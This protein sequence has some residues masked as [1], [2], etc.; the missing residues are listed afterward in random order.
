MAGI[1]YRSGTN[2]DLV[3][4]A[5]QLL[6]SQVIEQRN[7]RWLCH[8]TP[9]ANLE[10]IKQNGLKTRDLLFDWETTVTDPTRF[11]RFQNAICLSISKPNSWMFN[12]KQEQGLDLC[13]LLISPEVL[14]KKN[15]LFYPHNAATAS[16]RNINIEILK[17]EKG[18]E[19]MFSNPISYQ[20]SGMPPQDIFRFHYLLPCETTSEQAE[21][22]CL[23]NIEPQYIQHIFEYDIPL[24]YDE[25]K[26]Q[27]DGH[28]SIYAPTFEQFDKLLSEAPNKLEVVHFKENKVYKGIRGK[29]R[30]LPF[31]DEKK[32]N[33]GENNTKKRSIKELIATSTPQIEFIR[34][35]L[36]ESIT[37]NKTIDYGSID[38]NKFLKSSLRSW[39]NAREKTT[40]IFKQSILSASELL[41]I[42]EKTKQTFNNSGLKTVADEKKKRR[43]L[44]MLLLRY[45][46]NENLKQDLLNT[47][48]KEKVSL[49]VNDETSRE[50]RFFGVENELKESWLNAREKTTKAYQQSILDI[51]D[52]VDI[53]DEVEVIYDTS[54]LRTVTDEKEKT[55]QLLHRYEYKENL[56]QELLKSREKCK[57]AFEESS[58]SPEEL[59]EIENIVE[60]AFEERSGNSLSDNSIGKN[61][62]VSITSSKIEKNRSGYI[63]IVL[64]ILLI[65]L[66]VFI[67]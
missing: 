19:N 56:K 28:K 18:L 62:K 6:I 65:L 10:N 7:I 66:V 31:V 61:S 27:V 36:F 55:R 1:Y 33:D 17:G 38:E 39:L 46:L 47:S 64:F 20:K 35:S 25:I 42:E 14:F 22:Q 24:T 32:L 34:T 3:L 4:D 58:L 54:D 43:E 67:L 60:Q 5:D 63:C 59:Q 12:R 21:V 13:L 57:K 40:K 50:E 8:F 44:F 51:K 11:D 26:S 48:I 30:Y 45:E 16:Y 53:E 37:E 29:Y 2:W 49:S 9:R 52:I 23:E 15:C 41:V